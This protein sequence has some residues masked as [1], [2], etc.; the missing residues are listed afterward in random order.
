MTRS[1]PRAFWI[2]TAILALVTVERL[3]ELSL[4]TPQ[5]VSALLTGWWSFPQRTFPNVTTN[6]SAIGMVAICSAIALGT[7]QFLGRSLTGGRDRRWRWKWTLSAF[8]AVWLLFLVSIAASGLGR[9]LYE[10][11]LQNRR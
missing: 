7:M 9:N 8:S 2:A 6:P 3:V 4:N 5:G 10:L 11:L 1:A